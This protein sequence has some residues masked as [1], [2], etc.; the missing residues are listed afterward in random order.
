MVLGLCEDEA[1]FTFIRRSQYK[2]NLTL[3]LILKFNEDETKRLMSIK[4]LGNL[5]N[6]NLH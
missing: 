3:L 5:V 1:K 4:L 2:Y 6:E